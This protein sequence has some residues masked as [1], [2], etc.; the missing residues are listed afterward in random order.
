MQLVQGISFLK[1]VDFE[2]MK[3]NIA[4]WENHVVKIPFKTNSTTE[5][6]ELV[7]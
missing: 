1:T 5:D 4:S 2:F 6:G 7:N 3:N